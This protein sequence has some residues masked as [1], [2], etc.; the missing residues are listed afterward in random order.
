MTKVNGIIFENEN[1]VTNMLRNQGL[2]NVCDVGG[3]LCFSA[4][5]FMQRPAMK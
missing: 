4:N 1:E 5:F 3:Q 2:G